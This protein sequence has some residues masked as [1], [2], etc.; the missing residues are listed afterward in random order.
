MTAAKTAW[1]VRHVSFEDLGVLEPLLQARGYGLRYLDA[2][3]DDL[4]ELD[5]TRPDLLVVL[6]GPMG[7]TDVDLHPFLRT[8]LDWLR[9]RRQALLPSLGICLGAQLMAVAAGGDVR[10]MPRREIGMG[11]LTLTA[12][13]MDSCLAALAADAAVLHWH[14]DAIVLPD[15]VFP[16]ASTAACAVQAFALPGPSLGLQFHLEADLRRIGAWTRGHAAELRAA[17]LDPSR[18]EAEAALHADTLAAGAARVFS[19]W[20][21]AL[22]ARDGTSGRGAACI[23]S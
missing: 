23:A 12:A 15:E 1:A 14:G 18:I 13:G 19:A 11:P 3:R 8:E 2:G 7:A 22:P 10:T 17:G 21:D 9:R 6:G 5:P 16:L 4:S 20:L